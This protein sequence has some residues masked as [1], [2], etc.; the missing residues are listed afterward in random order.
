M[1]DEGNKDQW[2]LDTRISGH[3]AHRVDVAQ[4]G[5]NIESLRASTTHSPHAHMQMRLQLQ[6]TCSCYH[7]KKIEKKL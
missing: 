3:V 1:V 2:L 7:E 4:L 6:Y 5:T